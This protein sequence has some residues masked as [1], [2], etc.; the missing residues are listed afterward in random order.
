VLLD[1]N[2]SRAFDAY[3]GYM[4]TKGNHGMVAG[5]ASDRVAH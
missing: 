3:F 4:A 5:Y 2:F 1:Y